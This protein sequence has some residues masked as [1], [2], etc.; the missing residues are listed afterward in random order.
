MERSEHTDDEEEVE[1]QAKVGNIACLHAIHHHHHNHQQHQSDN[2]RNHTAADG[3]FTQRRT[4]HAFA[5]DIGAS[6]HLTGFEHV[7]QVGSFFHGKVTGDFGVAFSD[8]ILHVR[9]RVNHVVEHHS[10]LAADV[11]TGEA[12]PLTCALIVHLHG[13]GLTLKLFETRVGIHHHVARHRRT[14]VHGFQC[15]ERHVAVFLCFHIP[16][17]LEVAA[18]HAIASNHR[19][20]SGFVFFLGIAHH[21]TVAHD[22]ECLCNIEIAFFHLGSGSLFGAVGSSRVG[23]FL[24]FGSLFAG[25][26]SHK[27]LEVVG[28]FAV[29]IS[30]IEFEVSS[31]LEHL[32]H[33]LAVLHTGELHEDAVGVG[34]LL[35]VR[36]SDTHFFDTS[37]EHIEGVFHLSLHF[38]FKDGFHLI[39][40]QIGIFFDFSHFFAED[41]LPVA[42][43][44]IFECLAEFV[45]R[46]VGAF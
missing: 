18:N 8:L 24:S 1:N 32:L 12:R 33:T 35:E 6:H 39:I 37:G 25:S 44:A 31:L 17:E 34:Q 7:G 36:L 29:F 11:G 9:I 3:F 42:T 14:S 40:F 28:N 10:H 45:N 38:I 20:D 13:H 46:V 43:A 23:S 41:R 21:A 5:N 30:L 16:A 19:V 4:N 2:E 15:D 26:H 22:L 27:L